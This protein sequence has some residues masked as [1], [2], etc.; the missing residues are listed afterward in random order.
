M[1]RAARD[2]VHGHT[3]VWGKQLPPWLTERTWTREELRSFLERYV[4]A[5]MGRYRGRIESWDVVNEPLAEDGSLQH[6]LWRRVLGP[7][8]VADA[9]RWAHEADPAPGCT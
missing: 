6:N 7:G 2:R 5:V 4:K 9:L 8:Y 3:L 1:E